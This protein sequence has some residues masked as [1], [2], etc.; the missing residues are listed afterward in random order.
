VRDSKLSDGSPVLNFTA[1]QWSVFVTDVRGD[2]I[3]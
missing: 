1:A 2:R 3:G